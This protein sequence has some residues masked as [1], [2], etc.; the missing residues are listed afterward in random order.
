MYNNYLRFIS[1]FMFLTLPR[2]YHGVFMKYIQGI[3]IITQS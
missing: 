1:R 2:V 3:L